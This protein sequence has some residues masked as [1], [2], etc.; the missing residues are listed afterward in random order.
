RRG[1]FRAVAF[2][3]TEPAG[4]EQDGRDRFGSRIG[5]K[6]AKVNQI[7][8]TTPKT[9]NRIKRE[10]GIPAATT[11]FGHLKKLVEAGRVVRT[12]AGYRLANEAEPPPKKPQGY[13]PR[14]RFWEGL[15]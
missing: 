8:T 7:L 5:S 9:P 2:R 12:D 3:R 1:L 15:L 13:G 11:I 14:R 4:R 10:A 6:A